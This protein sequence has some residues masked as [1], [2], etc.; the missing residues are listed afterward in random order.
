MPKTFVYEK[1]R[2]DVKSSF[3]LEAYEKLAKRAKRND[4][5]LGREVVAIV[6]R[7]LAQEEMQEQQWPPSLER[8]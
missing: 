6:S 5:S 1:D 7:A 8:K 4:R 3:S 2:K